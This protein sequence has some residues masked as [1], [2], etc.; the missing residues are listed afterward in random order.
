MHRVVVLVLASLVSCGSPAEQ[1]RDDT[2]SGSE[3]PDV[4]RA[5]E[6]APQQDAAPNAILA[7]HNARRAEHC[8][9][10]LV[11]SDALAQTAQ[12]WA[13]HL[14][15]N[16]CQLEHSQGAYGENLAAGTSGSL[17]PEDVVSMWYRESEHYRF[18]HGGFSM[19][20]GHFTQLVWVGTTS[21]GCGTTTCNGLDVFVCNYDPP[22]DVEGQYRENVLPTSCR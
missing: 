18:A 17:S 10:P 22:G 4:T 21:L 20:T 5:D 19:Q 1:Q 9:R 3:A 2:A 11:W 8:A 7:A 15:A 13:D 12:R 14:A 16:G 6:P